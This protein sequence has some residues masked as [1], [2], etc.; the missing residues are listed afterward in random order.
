MSDSASSLRRRSFL[1]S[2][3]GGVVAGGVGG[4]AVHR[5]MSGETAE[6]AQ[7]EA[8]PSAS[9]PTSASVAESPSSH[10]VGIADE[11]L[12]VATLMA[13]DVADS[14]TVDDARRV[15]RVWTEDAAKLMAA[16]APLADPEPELISP[17]PLTITL[18]IGPGFFTKLDLGDHKPDWLSQLPSFSIDKLEDRWSGG[19]LLLQVCGDD[20]AAVSHAVRALS[21]SGLSLVTPRWSQR[22]F[23]GPTRAQRQ[24]MGHGHVRNAFGQVDGTVNVDSTTDVGK[25]ALWLTSTDGAPGW[26]DGGTTMVVRRI[27]MDMTGWDRTSRPVR[28]KTIGRKLSDGAPLTGGTAE[29]MGNFDKVGGDGKPVIPHD[30]HMRRARAGDDSLRILRRGYSYETDNAEQDKNGTGLIFI[31]FQ[32]DLE[33]QFIATQ[34]AL[35]ESDA[36]NEWT[37][38]IGSAVFAVPR[39]PSAGEYYLQDLLG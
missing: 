2:V 16:T 5:A 35:A 7:G 11:A 24:A 18:A 23:R 27:A 3:G 4:F 20:P 29:D 12:D 19:D 10:Q 38:P 32:R 1:A 36:L 8:G 13:F 34:R 15:M 30:A 6:T 25:R 37:T 21:T 14:A 31:A 28:E 33:T 9:S 17:T 39:A 26:L 22:G